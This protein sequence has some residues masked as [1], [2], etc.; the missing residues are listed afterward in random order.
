MASSLLTHNALLPLPL[1]LLAANMAGRC[2]S[3]RVGW[4]SPFKLQTRSAP[5]PAGSLV[6]RQHLDV[7]A[8]ATAA[9]LTPPPL[10][11]PL[12]QTQLLRPSLS[13]TK[14]FFFFIPLCQAGVFP[15]SLTWILH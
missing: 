11:P 15:S 9:S 3:R 13:F 4:G 14:S 6:L 7:V 2:L 10:P 12:P 1:P 5:P 8:M